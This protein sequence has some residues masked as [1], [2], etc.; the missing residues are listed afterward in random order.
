MSKVERRRRW[1]REDKLRIMDKALMSGS[2]TVPSDAA[3]SLVVRAKLA[4]TP[5]CRPVQTI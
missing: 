2:V 4:I 1:G 5:E 3:R